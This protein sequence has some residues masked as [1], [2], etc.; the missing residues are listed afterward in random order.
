MTDTGFLTNNYIDSK[1]V[2]HQKYNLHMIQK[3][4]EEEKTF[5]L[6]YFL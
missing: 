4:Q 2:T 5:F 1:Y 6:Q 3:K